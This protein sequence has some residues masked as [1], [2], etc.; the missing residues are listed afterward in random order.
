MSSSV[1][2]VLG[3]DRIKEICGKHGLTVEDEQIVDEILERWENLVGQIAEKMA[4]L[5]E[6]IGRHPRVSLI[7]K[8]LLEITFEF[9]QKSWGVST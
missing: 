1:H 3:A 9:T 2:R 4:V 7:S 6:L 5:E 8:A